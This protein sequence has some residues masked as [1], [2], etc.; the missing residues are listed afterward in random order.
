[1]EKYAMNDITGV[2]TDAQLSG[3]LCRGLL[4]GASFGLMACAGC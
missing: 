1:M 2:S 4:S 3:D